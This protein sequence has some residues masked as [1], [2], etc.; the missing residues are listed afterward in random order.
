MLAGGHLSAETRLGEIPERDRAINVLQAAVCAVMAG[1]LPAYFPVV[2][3][4]WDA[5]LQPEF[6]AN[7]VF[8]STGG[9][10]I[11]AV[12]SGPYAKRIGMNS[13]RGLLSPGN[14]ANAT[15]GRAIR[16]GAMLVLGARPGGLDAA[17]FGHAGKF[18]QHFAEMD[19]PPP[20]VPLRVREGWAESDTTVTIIPTEAP[21]Q[22]HQSLNN[23]P[24]GVLR[25]FVAC[26]SDA[27][28]NGAGKST[29]YVVVMGPEHARLLADAG[30][31]QDEVR[32]YLASES[33]LS[34]EDFHR[35]G[36]LLD[37]GFYDMKPEEDGKLTTCPEDH[38]VLTTAGGEG[39]GWSLVIPCWTGGM[40]T[41]P[42]TRP[43]Y[44]SPERIEAP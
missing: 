40:N 29:Y 15:I 30:I 5:I 22:M 42:V 41:K 26:M 20:W 8:S 19:P 10:A 24:D 39:A 21:R 14:R 9:S 38:I 32:R 23:D 11:S 3:A 7:G 2:L 12:V 28:Q 17:S 44:T 43:V 18:T 1:A 37:D 16:L 25:S 13:G 27:T 6:N 4:T 35:A 33:R 34:V 36:I 31:S